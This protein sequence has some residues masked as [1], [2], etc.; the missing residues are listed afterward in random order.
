MSNISIPFECPVC[1]SDGFKQ[2]EV[3]GRDGASRV[4]QA[5]ECRGCSTMFRERDQFTKHRRQVMGAD[6]KDLKPVID[7]RRSG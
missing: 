4:T 1:G 5:Y 6:G 7:K 2:V 3:K